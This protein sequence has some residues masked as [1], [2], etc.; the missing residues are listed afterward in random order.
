[1]VNHQ[2]E[3]TVPY[4]CSY[5]GFIM[6]T[7]CFYSSAFSYM[8][9]GHKSRLKDNTQPSSRSPP[10]QVLNVK[11]KQKNSFC[12]FEHFSFAFGHSKHLMWCSQS[13]KIS[14]CS[15][16]VLKAGRMNGCQS[17]LNYSRVPWIFFFS[18]SLSLHPPLPPPPSRHSQVCQAKM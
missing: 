14:K 6:V 17:G 4:L 16:I 12:F 18:L 2:N 7:K 8:Q 9:R 1:M 10:V 13:K 3:R 11:K 15:Q 5:I